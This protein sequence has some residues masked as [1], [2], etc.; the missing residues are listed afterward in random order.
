MADSQFLSETNICGQ[1]L[2]RL[3][4]RGSAIVAELLRLSKYIPSVFQND[5]PK[6]EHAP[7]LYDF[8]YL[9]QFELIEHKIEARPDLVDMDAQFRDTYLP[10]LGRFFKLFESIYKYVADFKRFL[11]DLDEGVFIQQTFTSVLVDAQ[12]KQLL[13]EALYLYGVMLLIMDARIEGLVRER[14]LMSY[15]RYVGTV[16]IENL[17]DICRLCRSTDKK[18]KTYPDELFAR[19]TISQSH[20]LMIIGRLRSDDIYQQMAFYPNPDHR[21]T[22]LASQASMLFVLLYFVPQVL[23]SEA[24][25]MRE[26]VDKFFPDNWIITFYMGIRVDLSECWTGYKAASDAL[27]NTLTSENIR[28]LLGVYVTKLQRSRVDVQ[29]Y[30]IEG[31]LT[32][33]EALDHT[34]KLIEV[35]RE[36]NV[37]IRWLMLH[38]SANNVSD[39][40]SREI[41]ELLTRTIAREEVLLLLLDTAQFEYA[42]NEMFSRLLK[43]KKSKWDDAKNTIQKRLD[44]LSQ[45]FSGTAMLT[46]KVKDEQLM[47]WFANMANKIRELDYEDS[48]LSGRKIQ[49]MSSALEG[50]EQFHQIESSL[51]VKQ[52]LAISRELLHKMIRII[53]IREEVLVTLGQVGDMSYAWEVAATYVALMQS[54]VQREP[55]LVIKLRATFL[56]LASILELPLVRITQANSPDLVSVSEYYSTELVAFVKS[57]LAIIPQSMFIILQQIIDVQQG[58]KPLPTKLNRVNLKDFAQL[59]QRYALAQLTY[60]VSNY[61]VGIMS[62]EK[63]LMGIIQLD[64]RLL[65]EDGIRREVRRRIAVAFRDYLSYDKLEPLANIMGGMKRSLEYIQDYVNIYGLKVWQDEFHRVV[66]VCMDYELNPFSHTLNSDD[67]LQGSLGS[68]GRLLTEIQQQTGLSRTTYVDAAS[69]WVDF[70]G[71]EVVG[72]ATFSLIRAA[73]GIAGL[74]ALDRLLAFAIVKDLQQAVRFSAPSPILVELICRIGQ[75]QLLR[76]HIASELQFACRVHA[77]QLY[78][79]IDV[80]NNAVLADIEA[81]YRAPEKKKYPDDDENPMLLPRL[82]DLL[83]IAGMT[84]PLTKIYITTDSLEHITLLCKDAVRLA[85]ARI[86]YDPVLDTISRP[87]SKKKDDAAPIDGVP[88]LLGICTLLKQFHSEYRIRFINALCNDVANSV[89]AMNPLPKSKGESPAE[90]PADA[91]AIL[92]FLSKF[93][94]VANLD[95][96]YLENQLPPFIV[97]EFLANA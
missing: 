38:A 19:Y 52:Y 41:K 8:R 39:S 50:V 42:L 87:L 44:E 9:N 86:S 21:S 51:Q 5:N 32:E 47:Q 67:F 27:R 29:H 23:R 54:H 89:A 66:R 34:G 84:D 6:A 20:T 59:D 48:T 43:E 3:V 55:K 78:S 82:S 11:G 64:P 68:F 17:E 45:Y 90:L 65:L 77:N 40:K 62:M 28:R 69:A 13:A 61:T 56:K 91:T 88:F 31:N 1:T 97:D 2:L 14:M 12:G 60:E 96:S 18:S 72:V 4:S 49:Q 36:A 53:N 35:L 57:V 63:T 70:S 95:R 94:K 37:A 93:S 73:I 22:A 81:H 76:K 33:A 74:N 71:K 24:T 58:L 80:L 15:F 30:L 16:D 79:A 26:I 25:M 83:E 75:K 46:E 7:L 10:V 85:L 92:H